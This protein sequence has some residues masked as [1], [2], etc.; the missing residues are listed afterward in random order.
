MDVCVTACAA[1]HLTLITCL[2]F[3]TV[4]VGHTKPVVETKKRQAKDELAPLVDAFTLGVSL[5]RG[6]SEIGASI[7]AA[8]AAG[9]AKYGA[10]GAVP[11]P[12]T[13]RPLQG[14]GATLFCAGS[15]ASVRA[16]LSKFTSIVRAVSRVTNVLVDQ[17]CSS[18]EIQIAVGSIKKSLVGKSCQGAIDAMRGA[19]GGSSSATRQALVALVESIAD[20]T[21]VANKIDGVKLGLVLDGV[22]VALCS[23]SQAEC[24]GIGVVTNPTDDAYVTKLVRTLAGAVRTVAVSNAKVR[25]GIAMTAVRGMDRDF[26]DI[27]AVVRS[28]DV[29]QGCLMLKKILETQATMSEPGAASV[30]S[31]VR[32]SL[33]SVVCADAT[34]LSAMSP[35][36]LKELV[37]STITAV[38]S[39]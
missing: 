2:M 16:G 23:P 5:T 8:G 38:C 28:R 11:A 18:G 4:V 19:T 15:P 31:V 3:L 39:V 37:L 12:Y 35:A 14:D 25:C 33:V 34:A 24:D 6:V 1:T 17:M 13:K 21:C 9:A 10:A 32:A 26:D 30:A 36:E 7:T 22:A 20:A 29:T 27:A